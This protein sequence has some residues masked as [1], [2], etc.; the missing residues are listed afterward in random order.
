MAIENEGQ[1]NLDEL[2]AALAG[3]FFGYV[4]G[5]RKFDDWKP[6][7]ESYNTRMSHLTYFRVLKPLSLIRTIPETNSIYKEA[8][9]SYLFGLPNASI[10]MS[11]RCFE[12]G[13]TYVHKQETGR[14]KDTTY[15]MIEWAEQYLGNQKELAH[16]FRLVRNLIHE[17]TLMSEQTAL[18]T[19]VHISD[20]TNRL[21]TPPEYGILNYPCG[22]CGRQLTTNVPIQECYLGNI[23]SSRCNYCSQA[24]NTLVI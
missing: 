6:V 9:L 12:T 5:S 20:I 16:G 1:R 21:F 7:I 19:I 11:F 2:I 22:R 18:E 8:V 4:A 15:N 14:S 17:Q 23:L 24:T 3:G 10:P 13:L